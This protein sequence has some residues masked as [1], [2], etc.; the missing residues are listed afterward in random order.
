M[1]YPRPEY[2]SGLPF[3]PPG[4]LPNPSTKPT[5]WQAIL[6]HWALLKL[7]QCYMSTACMCAKSLQSRLTLCDRV[8]HS[9]SG[10]SVHGILQARILEWVAMPVSRGS[11]QPRDW[12]RV[13][14]VSCIGRQFLYHLCYVIPQ[15]SWW[16]W[17]ILEKDNPQKREKYLLIVY[18]I[19][20]CI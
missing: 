5:S 19:R 9:L 14:Y 7:T 1:G 20:A 6:Y 15:Q 16:E 2:W 13:S 4:D 18:A 10:S 11:S 3:P 17:N 12:T 8:D